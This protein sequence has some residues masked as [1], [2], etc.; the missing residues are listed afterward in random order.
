LLF[1]IE[2]T[3]ARAHARD[4]QN[5]TKVVL[6]RLAHAFQSNVS[7]NSWHIG[8]VHL[9]DDDRAARGATASLERTLTRNKRI[10]EGSSSLLTHT[11]VDWFFSNK[12]ATCDAM[13]CCFS[14]GAWRV[15]ESLG[16]GRTRA[17][18]RARRIGADES[19]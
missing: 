18:V 5:E 8:D 3:H 6:T 14:V 1:V 10:A 11:L 9:A 15:A 2:H 12:T 13:R 16:I 19:L 17:R 7:I 4:T